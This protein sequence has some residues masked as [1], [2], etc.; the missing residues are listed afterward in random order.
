MCLMSAAV[1]G[2]FSSDIVADAV[3]LLVDRG[4]DPF[5]LAEQFRIGE[6]I[7]DGNGLPWL[8]EG[9]C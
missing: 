8:V 9:D 4:F 7:E 2:S 1:L 3:H 6:G 5:R